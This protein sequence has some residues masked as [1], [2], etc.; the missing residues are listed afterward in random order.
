MDSPHG[1][2]GWVSWSALLISTAAAVFAAHALRL[3]AAYLLGA[4]FAAVLI[5]ASERTV[6]IPKPVFLSAEAL[7]GC[8]IAGALRLDM[9]VASARHWPA[10]VA[11][12]FAVL[13]ASCAISALLMRWRVL[14]GTTAIWGLFPGAALVMT[15]MA[16]EYG[17]DVRLV[18]LMQYLRVV[19]VAAAASLVMR[20]GTAG[21]LAAAAAPN[22]PID[23]HGAL[24]TLLFAGVSAALGGKLPIP[25]AALLVPM[26][27]G[28]FLQDLGIL[29]LVLPAP[30]LAASYCVVGWSIGLRF[31][32]GMLQ[33]AARMLP[34]VFAA[35]LAL[36]VI[37]AGFAYLLVRF[38]GV[39]PLSAYLA[40]SPG[41]A[42][43]VAIIAAG[44]HVDFPFV[45][46][47]QTARFLLVLAVGPA[48]ARRLARRA[49]R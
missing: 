15:L 28:A 4:L 16:E 1:R 40:T 8:M 6:D 43:S 9:L 48:L 34:A 37:C 11:G 10:L 26:F 27:A 13:L 23:G 20:F 44:S 3:P 7:I 19:M 18:A 33:N 2:S 24:V 45:I 5:A 22:S 47:M 42:D 46:S 41:G 14:P 17:E 49:S 35:L 38:A 25:A 31:S 39:D 32:R 36:L 30:L 12:V 21:T 29:K